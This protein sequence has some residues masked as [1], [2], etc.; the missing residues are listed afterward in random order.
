MPDTEAAVS[1]TSSAVGVVCSTSELLVKTTTCERKPPAS[2]VFVAQSKQLAFNRCTHLQTHDPAEAMN[3][4]IISENRQ[5][6]KYR[7]ESHK[8]VNRKETHKES[9]RNTM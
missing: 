6:G 9:M 7:R 4:V 1:F 5:K 2:C 8:Q 3:V